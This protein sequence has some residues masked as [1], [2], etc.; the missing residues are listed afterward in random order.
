M[1]RSQTQYLSDIEEAM[2]DAQEFAEGRSLEDFRKD[3]QLRYAIERALEI[4][5]VA[6]QQLS[7]PT[8][9]SVETK[10]YHGERCEDSGISSLTPTIVLMLLECGRS[11]PTTYLKHTIRSKLFWRE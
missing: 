6:W 4:I 5:G 1:A 3:R 8:R 11:S 10:A 9:S 2:A 7:F